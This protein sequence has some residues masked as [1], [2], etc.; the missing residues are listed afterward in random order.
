MGADLRAP[1]I[2]ADVGGTHARMALVQAGAGGA[3]E[4]LQHHHYQGGDYPG[5]DAIVADFAGTL[6]RKA[7]NA[8]IACAG[9][10]RD[11]VLISS[12]LPWP[13][14]LADLRRLGFADV[15]VINDFA[16]IAHADQCMQAEGNLALTPHASDAQPDAV[17][18]VVGPGT[19]L[20]SAIRVPRGDGVLVLPSEAS[21]MAFAPGTAREIAVLAYLRQQQDGHVHNQQL[22]SGP[23]LLNLYRVLCALDGVATAQATPADV[24]EAARRGDDPHA[25]EA[26]QVFC[27]IFGSLVADLVM[28]TGAGRVFVAGGIAPKISDFLAGREFNERLL[29][30]GVM[31]PL[32]EHVPVHLIDNPHAGVIGAATW[33]LAQRQP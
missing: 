9:V 18:L 5:L 30:K 32:L 23:G 19:G 33:R 16:A 17:T 6:E 29:D 2:A 15:S 28:A 26:M 1:F 24:P 10:A 31:R 21:Y 4:I 8:V 7:D 13:V 25:V 11:D 14:A 12:N 27:G 3:I 22:V 20:G